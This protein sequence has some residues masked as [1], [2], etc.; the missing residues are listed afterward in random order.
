MWFHFGSVCWALWLNRNNDIFNNKI[1]SSPC[2]II[3]RLISFLQHWMTVSSREDR[4]M[5]ER[6]VEEVRS[7]VPEEL[8]AT[9]VG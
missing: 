5:L 3:S 8:V 6:M 4:A 7:Q 9:G 2:V 1:I